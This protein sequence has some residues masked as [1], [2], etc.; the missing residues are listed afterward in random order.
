MVV[1]AHGPPPQTIVQIGNTANFI[2]IE[3]FVM[4]KPKASPV[5]FFPGFPE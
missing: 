5:D 1:T 2:V 3:P 4:R